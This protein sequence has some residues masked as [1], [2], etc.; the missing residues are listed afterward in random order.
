MFPAV[1]SLLLL[2]NSHVHPQGDHTAQEPGSL[3]YCDAVTS[4]H[5]MQVRSFA[6][7][8]RLRQMRAD[9]SAIGFYCVPIP[10]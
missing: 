4:L 5:F 3:F 10:C 2:L 8:N 9:C 6:R 7:R 1:D